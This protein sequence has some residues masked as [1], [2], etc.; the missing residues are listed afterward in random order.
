M[1]VTGGSGAIGAAIAR[2]AAHHG[3]DVCLTYVGNH[4]VAD[5]VARVVESAGR[6]ALVARVDVGIEA[7]VLALFDRVDR[8]WGGV[9]CLVNNAG[10]APG[11]GP[12][13]EL[14]GPDIE[15]T[16][17]VNVAGAM[18]CS[19]E[20]VRRMATDRGGDGGS[21]VNI[22]SKAAVLGGTGEWI[23]YAASK[24]ALETVTVG[25]A[26][27]VASQGIRVNAVRPGLIEG[28]FGPWAPEGRVEAMVA[29]I[30]MQRAGTPEEVAEAV[31]WLASPQ[32][33]YVTGAV[34]D[35]TGGR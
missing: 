23:H 29:G 3:W 13:D 25:L 17:S 35:V 21:I 15:R 19:R 20:A 9:D 18:L 32:A 14:A 11:Y 30:P 31:L 7:D 33:A 8:E 16:L 24:A 1:V 34:V 27:E 26:K 28:G 22:S 4:T 12:F 2:L 10:I 6:R 5:E